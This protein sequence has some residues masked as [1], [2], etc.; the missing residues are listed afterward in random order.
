MSSHTYCDPLGHMMLA[1]NVTLDHTRLG[2]LGDVCHSWG[3]DCVAVICPTVLGQES[4]Q[5]LPSSKLR[6]SSQR[7]HLNPLRIQA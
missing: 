2:G 7:Y 5:T 4:D 3:E 1:E 6:S